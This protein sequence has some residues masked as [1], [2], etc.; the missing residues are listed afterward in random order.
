MDIEYCY[1]G[2]CFQNVDISISE[3]REEY[4][5]DAI[6]LESDVFYELRKENNILPNK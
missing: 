5:D 3:Y 6:I 2:N 1:S 4:F